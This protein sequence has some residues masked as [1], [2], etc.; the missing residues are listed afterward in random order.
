MLYKDSLKLKPNADSFEGNTI[1]SVCIAQHS[2]GINIVLGKSNGLFGSKTL[3]HA[4]IL[5]LSEEG[6]ALAEWV[7]NNIIDAERIPY[8]QC[9]EMENQ[10]SVYVRAAHYQV[11]GISESGSVVTMH[12]KTRQ[13][14][15]RLRDYLLAN[16]WHSFLDKVKCTRCTVTPL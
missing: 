16:V 14:A 9:S 2:T 1:D 7:Q 6:N 4:H 11:Q 15:E 8:F 13:S 12:T 5:T 3:H 10:H